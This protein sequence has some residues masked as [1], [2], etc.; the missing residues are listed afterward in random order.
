MK[1]F[2]IRVDDK[3]REQLKLACDANATTPS[4][5]ARKLVTDWVNS[6]S[7]AVSAPC[8]IKENQNEEYHNQRLSI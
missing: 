5:I 4:Q 6:Q 1:T 3:V 7:Y 2:T 8:L